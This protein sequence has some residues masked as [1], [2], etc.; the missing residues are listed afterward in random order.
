[1]NENM[2][3]NMNDRNV[4]ENL[5]LLEKGA[6]DLYMHGAI[7]ASDQNVF[8]SFSS[9]LQQSLQLQNQIYTKM[10]EHIKKIALAIVSVCMVLL[11]IHAEYNRENIT[12]ETSLFFIVENE[13]IRTWE[14]EGV[15]Y[16]FLP[17]FAKET[18]VSKNYD[19]GVGG[20]D[21]RTGFVAAS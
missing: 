7:E 6:C 1:M 17:S 3:V 14:K 21:Y 19:A 11:L 16:L 9:A 10:K 12:E 18:E 20:R 13:V 4:M 8:S 5:L 2:N 15:Q